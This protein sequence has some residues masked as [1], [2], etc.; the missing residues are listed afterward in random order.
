[1]QK[2]ESK[3]KALQYMILMVIGMIVI[4][5]EPVEREKRG[6]FGPDGKPYD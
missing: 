3:M 1:M 4:E 6:L 2:N 5:G